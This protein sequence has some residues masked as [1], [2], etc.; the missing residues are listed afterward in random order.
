MRRTK[1]E[2][3]PC[4][5]RLDARASLTSNSTNIGRSPPASPGSICDICVFCSCVSFLKP[6]IRTLFALLVSSFYCAPS[7]NGHLLDTR[8]RTRPLFNT[9]LTFIV[10]AAPAPCPRPSAAPP[11]SHD[12]LFIFTSPPFFHL[13]AMTVL[14]TV[15]SLFF[16]WRL[17]A[18]YS[19][20]CTSP[21]NFSTPT[22]LFCRSTAC[23]LFLLRSCVC[24]VSGFWVLARSVGCSATLFAGSLPVFVRYFAAITSLPES[25]VFTLL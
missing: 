14:S 15:S 11:L 16:F 3:I 23:I 10:A 20:L 22:F 21:P 5:H 8:R 9:P 1:F 6:K 24:G 2:T 19:V 7:S 13:G 17:H 18:V 25:L 4:T 12:P